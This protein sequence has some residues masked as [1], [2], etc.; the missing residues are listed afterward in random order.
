MRFRQLA[1]TSGAVVVLLAGC[2]HATHPHAATAPRTP[3]TR[4]AA[5]SPPCLTAAQAF[6]VAT[7]GSSNS[8]ALDSDHGYA[9]AQGWAY[10]NYHVLPNGN[11][12]TK[13]LQFVDG[14]W[15]I[16][17]RLVVCGDGTR[18]PAMPAMIYAYGCGN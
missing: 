11:H 9:C 6:A 2:G 12:S 14:T 16:G 8:V 17:D 10:V 18:T 7:R 15:I 13:A 4:P 5:V 1:G 3:G